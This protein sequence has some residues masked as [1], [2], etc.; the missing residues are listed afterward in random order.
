MATTAFTAWYDDVIPQAPGCPLAIALNAIREAAIDFCKGSLVWRYLAAT[1]IDAVAAQQRYAIG[2]A[3]TAGTLPAD[4]AAAHLFQVNYN[5][6]ALIAAT[7]AQFRGLS[8]TWF[9]DQGDPQYFTLFAE[10]EIAL[11][12]IPSAGLVGAIV[13]P[14]LALAPSQAATGL[15]S[16]IYERYRKAI[17]KGALA[18]LLLM[19]EKPWSSPNLGE[20]YELDFNA[21]CGSADAR[22]SSGRG[23]ARLRTQTIYR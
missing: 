22:A 23:Q 19:P 6:A 17:A 5:G 10:G 16:A 20:K 4:T 11:W 13:I 12:Q 2:T 18:K 21:A 15:D 1:A 3:A 8:D 14:E 9:S 7:P